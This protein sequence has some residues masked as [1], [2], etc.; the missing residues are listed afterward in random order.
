[1][2]VFGRHRFHD[3]H[4]LCDKIIALTI[5]NG[6][7]CI[8]QQHALFCLQCKFK[9]SQVCLVFLRVKTYLHMVTTTYCSLWSREK[10][11]FALYVTSEALLYVSKVKQSPKRSGTNIGVLVLAHPTHTVKC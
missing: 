7:L 10:S 3:F 11:L 1:M 2:E 6:K 8:F 4:I 5:V 9:F